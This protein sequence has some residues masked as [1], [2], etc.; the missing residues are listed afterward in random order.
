MMAT[1][2]LDI[3]I[4][5]TSGCVWAHRRLFFST[6]PVAMD[7][8]GWGIID[9]KRVEKG[10]PIL[11]KTGKDFKTQGEHFTRRHPEHVSLAAKMGLDPAM[12]LRDH[13]DR[14]WPLSTGKVVSRLV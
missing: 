7:R 3:R 2:A 14:P 9:A 8:I 5:S 11:A 10:L 1:I 12:H 13:L 6:D 4:D